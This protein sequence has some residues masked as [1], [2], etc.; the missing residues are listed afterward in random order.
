MWALCDG[1]SHSNGRDWL[2]RRDGKLV[3]VLSQEPLIPQETC[4][5][6]YSEE[7]T[8]PPI[9]AGDVITLDATVNATVDRNGRRHDVV[10]DLRKRAP[11][12]SEKDALPLAL[13]EWWSRRPHLGAD[14]VSIDDATREKVRIK[15]RGRRIIFGRHE[16]RFVVRVRDVDAVVDLLA[17]GTGREKAYGCG[18]VTLV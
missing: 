3:R 17:N 18:M 7:W 8:P 13:S 10:T 4:W 9:E 1:G 5:I 14:L 6:E 2:Y 16:A 12:L 11:S 15:S